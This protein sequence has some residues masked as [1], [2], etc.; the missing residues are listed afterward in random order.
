MKTFKSLYGWVGSSPSII[1]CHWEGGPCWGYGMDRP[2]LFAAGA[3]RRGIQMSLPL[4][5]FLQRGLRLVF[6][7]GPGG[8]DRRDCTSSFPEVI[9]LPLLFCRPAAPRLLELQ[10]LNK[11]LTSFQVSFPHF[12]KQWTLAAKTEGK[13]KH[14]NQFSEIS[15]YQVNSLSTWLNV[16]ESSYSCQLHFT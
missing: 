6:R 5:E 14:K 4:F 7:V 9:H 11:Q 13:Q 8:D 16:C 12:S 10:A 15:S 2:H 1:C 3:V